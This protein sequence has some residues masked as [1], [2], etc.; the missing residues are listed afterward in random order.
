MGFVKY[1]EYNLLLLKLQLS[2][3]KI[4]N[5]V[6]SASKGSVKNTMRCY[7]FRATIPVIA[8][9]LCLL[10]NSTID[11]EVLAVQEW[12]NG[13]YAVWMALSVNTVDMPLGIGN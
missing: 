3:E 8:P 7:I 6:P 9:I 4:N 13:S 12:D 5:V 10:L 11:P 2:L 1:V